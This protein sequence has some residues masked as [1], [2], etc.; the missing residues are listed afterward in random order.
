V[1]NLS[2]Y[3][4][5]TVRE[6]IP[7]MSWLQDSSTYQAIIAEGEARSETRWRIAQARR[8][9]ITLG[10]DKFGAPSRSIVN[11]LERVDDLDR[12]ERLIRRVLTAESWVDS[13]HPNPS[14]RER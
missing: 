8:V 1:A 10:T 4:D 2:L 7:N 12:L 9:I 11:Q 13:S 14:A 5:R 6:V 3:D